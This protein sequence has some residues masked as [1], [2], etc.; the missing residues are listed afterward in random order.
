MSRVWLN[1]LCGVVVLVLAFAYFL[2]LAPY[3]FNL[4]DEGT[5]IYQIY[6]AYQGQTLYVD[7]H[8][9]YTPGVFLLNVEVFRLFGVNI[10][11][12]RVVLAAF[13]AVAALLIYVSARQIGVR[14]ASA[15][16]AAFVSVAMIPFYEGQFFPANIPYPY[17]YI[18]VFWLASILA[19]GRW[20]RGGSRAWWLAAG[21][22]AGLSFAFKPNSG[23][24]NLAAIFLA[25]AVTATSAAADPLRPSR[26]AAVVWWLRWLGIAAIVAGLSAMFGGGAGVRGFVLFAAPL[27]VVIVARGLW[28]M[29][30]VRPRPPTDVVLDGLLVVLGFAAANAWWVGYYWT[31]LG[32]R[33]F[34][35]AIL[36]I[37]ADFERFYF[38]AYPPLGTWGI[39][40]ATAFIAAAVVG[41]MMRKRWLPAGWIAAGLLVG[42]GLGLA[43]LRFLPPP[44]IEGLS[45]AVTSRLRDVSFALA[46]AVMWSAIAVWVAGV[47]RQ[48]PLTDYA[49]HSAP[50]VR[51]YQPGLILCTL[52]SAI[53][54]HTQIYPRTDFMHLV[55]ASPGLLILGA[56]LLD[57]L[58]R[59]W[60]RG[61]S[62]TPGAR[63]LVASLALVALVVPIA[64]MQKSAIKRA[65]DMIRVW[66]SGDSSGMIWLDDERATVAIEAG[67]SKLFR[68]VRA[69]TRFLREE[70]PAGARVFTFPVLDILCFLADRP[71]PT[72]HGYFYPGWPGHEVEAEVIEALQAKP[73]EYIVALHAHALFFAQ[74]PV[75]YFN[76]RR[77]V[78]SHYAIERRI[79]QFDVLRHGNATAAAGPGRGRSEMLADMKFWRDELR[80][81]AGASGRLA[82]TALSRVKRLEFGVLADAIRGLPPRAQHKVAHAVRQ[83]RSRLGASVL[84]ALATDTTLPASTRE[85]FLRV[86]SELADARAMPSLVKA[87]EGSLPADR[88]SYAGVLF[89]IASKSTVESFWWAP[90]PEPEWAELHDHVGDLIRWMDNPWEVLALRSFAVR[91]AGLSDARAAIPFLARLVGDPTDVDDLGVSAAASLVELGEGAKFVEPIGDLGDIDTRVPWAL[92]TRIAETT[93]EPV[94]AALPA[95]LRSKVSDIRAG[96]AWVAAGLMV[97]IDASQLDALSADTTAEVCQA[98]LWYRQRAGRSEMDEP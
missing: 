26:M 25:L 87:I 62:A 10:L 40:L 21:V 31:R 45:P 51:Q 48:R 30:G 54:M 55:P 6:R 29:P 44:M 19:V 27:V 67:A 23:L 60:T 38:I 5:L 50:G 49:G 53:L 59:S 2:A 84:A 69:T 28:S 35:R 1:R 96:A 43:V 58:L 11:W 73:P 47:R 52:L 14:R 79:G 34:L 81:H 33:G 18:T 12:L 17:W 91:A 77:W 95:L 76:L 20:W 88:A 36:F 64:I 24:L 66:H 89:N 46:L 71:N 16:F 42:V 56:W 90:T 75:Y 86:G 22:L 13:N 39:L 83:S 15:L 61:M 80:T 92:L 93:P 9:G 63:R 37:G 82:E 7:F 68:G 4:D 74:A 85:L 65:F 70:S 78:T 32:P 94:A 41:W 8:A 97:P 3:G 98:A 72:R 57:G